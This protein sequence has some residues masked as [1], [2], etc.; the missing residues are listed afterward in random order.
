MTLAQTE[1]LAELFTNLAAGWFGVIFITP[2]FT[3]TNTLSEFFLLLSRNL[4]LAILS[5]IVA[6]RIREEVKL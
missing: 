1:T 6:T 3:G 5:L 2:G 4:P